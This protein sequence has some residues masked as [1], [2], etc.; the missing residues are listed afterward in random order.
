MKQEG[1]DCIEL[2]LEIK[3]INVGLKDPR[4]F[5]FSI[6]V[7]N[8][9]VALWTW[10]HGDTTCCVDESANPIYESCHH[11]GACQPAHLTFDWNWIGVGM[12][13]ADHRRYAPTPSHLL[14]HWLGKQAS[15][16]K[17]MEHCVNPHSL[18][19][20]VPLKSQNY[21]SDSDVLNDR[22]WTNHVLSLGESQKYLL[23]TDHRV[24]SRRW[25]AGSIFYLLS[26]PYHQ[27]EG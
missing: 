1:R 10:N 7:D 25:V 9:S 14:W 6:S 13:P 21:S 8:I 20:S 2:L 22:K 15:M 27:I 3:E 12:N 5:C 18:L 17:S 19:S 16:L 26:S 4:G 11:V 24:F 23:T